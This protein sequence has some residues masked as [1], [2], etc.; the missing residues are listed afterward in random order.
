MSITDVF[1]QFGD[2]RNKSSGK[3]ASTLMEFS[4]IFGRSNKRLLGKTISS[5]VSPDSSVGQNDPN[6]I[7]FRPLYAHVLAV[8][9]WDEKSVEVIFSSYSTLNSLPHIQLAPCSQALC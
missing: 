4:P 2:V 6:R 1:C 5:E 9:W 7:L 3:A 8:N